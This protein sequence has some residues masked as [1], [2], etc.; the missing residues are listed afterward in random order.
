MNNAKINAVIFTVIKNSDTAFVNKF[1]EGECEQLAG[2]I[3]EAICNTLVRFS[4]SAE[5]LFDMDKPENEQTQAF[6]TGHIE[7]DSESSV[8]YA[9]KYK[10]PD[11]DTEWTDVWSCQCNDKCPTCNK[12]IE[13]YESKEV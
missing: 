13:P 12:E 6:V 2:E 4:E 9:N 10:C 11:D 7:M 5:G 8:L 3:T 1:E